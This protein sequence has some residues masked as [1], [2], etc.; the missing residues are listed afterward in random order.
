MGLRVS[1]EDD[2]ESKPLDQAVSILLFRAIRELLTNII[3]HSKAKNA[4]VS[5]SRDENSLRVCVEDDGRGFDINGSSVDG[6]GAVSAGGSAGFGLFSI[7][8]Q[9]DRIGGTM[10]IT[11][12]PGQGCRIVLTAPLQ[13]HA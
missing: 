4:R 1:F 7:R 9:L 6:G 5:L 8:E 11:S 13:T 2:E 10:H 12:A 3:K